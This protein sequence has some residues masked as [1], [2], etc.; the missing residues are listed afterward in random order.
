MKPKICTKW[1]DLTILVFDIVFKMA[2]YLS[3]N[4]SHII[5]AAKLI[6]S[7]TFKNSS[8]TKI[9]IFEK[10]LCSPMMRCKRADIYLTNILKVT[11]QKYH[12]EVFHHSKKYQTFNKSEEAIRAVKEG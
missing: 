5:F 2:K 11:L 1:K 3:Q 4:I 6:I 12:S 10:E 7:N 9:N 8:N